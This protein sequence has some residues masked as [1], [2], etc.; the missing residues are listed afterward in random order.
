MVPLPQVV[1]ATRWSTAHGV[2][3]RWRC[4]TSAASTFRAI[5]KRQCCIR[6]SPSNWKHFSA[7]NKSGTIR[8]PDSS[9]KNSA[10]FW[11]AEFWPGAFCV[12]GAKR[13][14]RIAWFPFRV[15]TGCVFFLWRAAHG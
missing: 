3:H 13:A 2:A 15:A 9:K 8:S 4:S 11:T 6:S 1:D 5:R 12:F 7:G 10:R 14:D